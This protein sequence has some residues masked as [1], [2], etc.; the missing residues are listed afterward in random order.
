[1]GFENHFP[2]GKH[3]LFKQMNP[4]YAVDDETY[5]TPDLNLTEKVS[6]W[7]IN[8]SKIDRFK[9]LS[10]YIMHCRD[11]TQPNLVLENSFVKSDSEIDG[12]VQVHHFGISQ[13]SHTIKYLRKEAIFLATKQPHILGWTRIFCRGAF[14]L[15][16][17]GIL[18]N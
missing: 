5:L 8:H 15:F 17:I 4:R 14:N 6:S 9:L 10:E 11:G 13:L 7:N 18:N 12:I 1:M 2:L 16:W 3:S